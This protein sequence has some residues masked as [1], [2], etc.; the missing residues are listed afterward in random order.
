M[1]PKIG[2]KRSVRIYNV[3]PKIIEWWREDGMIVRVLITSYQS[4]SDDRIVYFFNSI[5]FL[6]R[7]GVAR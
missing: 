4:W 5:V 3:N 7:C 6:R 2:Y 1:A